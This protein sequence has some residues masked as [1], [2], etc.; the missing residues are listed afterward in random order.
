MLRYIN[1]LR[2]KTP[3]STTNN[4]RTTLSPLN[5]PEIL[6]LIFSYLDDYTTRRWAA[7]VCRQWYL[8][9]QG[10]LAREVT[11]NQDWR[12]S[13]KERALLK[14]PGAGRFYI[15][16][17]SN[18]SDLMQDAIFALHRLESKY[19]KQ[20]GQ[21]ASTSAVSDNS[22]N[23]N[24]RISTSTAALTLYNFMPLR[25]LILYTAFGHPFIESFPIPSSLTRL[26]I[27]V[28]YSHYVEWDFGMI[29]SKCPLLEYFCADTFNTSDI[30][31]RLS[32]FDPTTTPRL[33][34]R[35]LVL[36]NVALP[37]PEL[38]I[39]LQL[40][41]DLK[42]L[43]LMAMLWH[44]GNQYNW[45][46]L[47]TYL[48]DNNI[49]LD[50]AHF[51]TLDRKMSAKETEQL[52]ADIYPHLSSERS[53]WALDV[54]PQLLQTI[55]SQSN[56]LTTLEVIWKAPERFAPKSCCLTSLAQAPG[57]IHQYLCES[58]YLAHLTTLKMIT[59]ET[60]PSY[61]TTPR[62]LSAI[63]GSGGVAVSAPSTSKSTPLA[64]FDFSTQ[65][66]V[67]SSLVTSLV[68]AH[69]SRT[70]RSV[71]QGTVSRKLSE[72]DTAHTHVYSSREG[73]ASLLD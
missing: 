26:A 9:N 63:L 22:D 48:M 23:S 65:S 42:E 31:L 73:S 30:H 34:L 51:S 64:R 11:W 70:S 8:L 50:R 12:S 2:Q 54:T 37:Q 44:E 17:L 6:E 40:T 28:G 10:R 7:L 21:G 15:C 58:P 38:E 19:L 24:K 16:H 41:P 35:S 4:T 33:P 60:T 36:H 66:T 3:V 27:K 49:T 67:A 43:K 61:Q 32:P 68:S 56:T 13:R 1:R 46:L 62:H 71:S 14:L 18:G 39:L 25:E 29:L 72:T 69:F 52:L 45:T 47:F 55:T 20:L 59:E 53:L 57:L 5:L